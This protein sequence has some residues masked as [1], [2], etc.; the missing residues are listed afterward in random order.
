MDERDDPGNLL[1]LAAGGISMT[2]LDPYKGPYEPSEDDLDMADFES[3][4]ARG[5]WAAVDAA[6]T[7]MDPDRAA[8]LQEMVLHAKGYVAWARATMVERTKR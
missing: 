5:D 7:A 3:A 8:P 2:Y 1:G 6:L 4:M